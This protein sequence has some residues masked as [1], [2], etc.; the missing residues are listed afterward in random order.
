MKNVLLFILA[1]GLTVG[2][3][4]SDNEKTAENKPAP[5][6]P[7]K[8]FAKM[9]TSKGE[10]TCELEFE[11]A[12]IT[13]ANFIGLAEGVTK[14]DEKE[15]GI[16]YYDGL[17][18]HKVVPDL[19]ILSGC[20][21][22]TGTG[23][24]GYRFPDEIDA[25]LT[26]N[27]PGILSMANAGGPDT[28]GSQFFITKKEAPSLDGRHSVFGHVVEGLDVVNAIEKDDILEKITIVRIGEKAAAFRSDPEAF[29]ELLK[30]HAN[31]RREKEI[32]AARAQREKV[33]AQFPD[34]EK[35]ESGLLYVITKEGT[36][37]QPKEGANVS[38]YY[39]GKLVDGTVW[40]SRNDKNEPPLQFILGEGGATQGWDEGISLMKQGEK[41]TLIMPP[42]LGY[43][44]QRVGPIPPHSWLIF[45]VEL[46]NAGEGE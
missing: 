5:P 24:P 9:I 3:G 6:P 30:A 43:G 8:I 18:F 17:T 2:S 33:H 44:S 31:A 41:R 34:A 45:D 22:G 29:K 42:S 16:P 32:N 40:S 1:V 37:A 19:M 26:H 7:S 27:R 36:G 25:S 35:T 4:C 28:N 12:P 46:V 20:P 38:V 13:V 11:K 39:T 10:I 21:K 23:S 14:N 15:V